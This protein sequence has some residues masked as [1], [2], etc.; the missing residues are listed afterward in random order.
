MQN[1]YP[2]IIALLILGSFSANAQSYLKGSVYESG[3]NNKLADVFIR[4]ANT[5]QLGITDKQ[6]NFSIKTEAGHTLIFDCPG[7]VSDTL[8]VVDL[9]QQ[10]IVLQTQTIALREVS[11][12]STR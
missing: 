8:Y 6:G 1:R 12:S 4:D 3:T 7:Y 10:K 9:T 2:C 5:K 11:I